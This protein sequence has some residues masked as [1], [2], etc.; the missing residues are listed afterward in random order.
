MTTTEKSDY[1]FVKEILRSWKCIRT[2]TKGNRM[3]H[4]FIAWSDE[5][6]NNYLL[7][8]IQ[9]GDYFYDYKEYFVNKTLKEIY[10]K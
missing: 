4:H 6:I 9:K 7:N 1:D 10:A 5:D 2:D 8:A 3:I